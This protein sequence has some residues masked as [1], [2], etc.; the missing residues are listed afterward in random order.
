MDKPEG[1]DE[2]LADENPQAAVAAQGM[3][4]LG[5]AVYQS[6]PVQNVI[7]GAPQQ[8]F[9]EDLQGAMSGDPQAEN[10]MAQHSLGMATMGIAQPAQEASGLILKAQ[11]LFPEAKTFDE[12]YKAADEVLAPSNPIMQALQQAKNRP[13]DLKQAQGLAKGGVVDPS[14]PP[15]VKI[16]VAKSPVIES[17]PQVTGDSEEPNEPPPGYEQFKSGAETQPTVVNREPSQTSE[18]PPPGYEE[19]IRPERLQRTHGTGEQQ[20][21]AALEGFGRGLVGPLAPALETSLGVNPEDIRKREEANP[22]THG[23]SEL[24]GF[25]APALTGAGGLSKLTQVGALEAIGAKLGLKATEGANL[26]SRIGTGAARGAIDNILLT[27]GDEV[28]KMIIQD[29]HQ[30]AQ[31][32]MGDIGLAGVIGASLGGGL[33]AIPALWKVASGTKLG[34]TAADFKAAIADHINNPEPVAA[35]TSELSDLYK[36]VTSVSD[37]VYGPTGLKAQD[38]A[39]HLPELSPEMSEQAQSTYNKMNDTVSK[40]GKDQASYPPRLTQKL[41][42]DL[43]KFSQAVSS[44]GA[45]SPAVYNAMQD[46]KQTLQG[47]SKYD[48]FVKP[49]DE[50]YDFV[51]TSKDLARDLRLSLED[52]SVW[53][54]AA[55]RQQAINKAFSEYLPKLKDFEKKFTTEVAGDRVIDSG[56]INTYINQLG[57]PNAEIKQTL[58]KNFIDASDKYKQVI[59]DTHANLGLEDLPLSSPLNATKA[60]FKEKTLGSKLAQAVIE[61]GLTD[62]G[63]KGLGAATGAGVSSHL[64]LGKE[65]GAY[66]G[67]HALGPFFSSVLPALARPLVDGVASGEGFKAAADYAATVAKASN[68]IDK[69]TAYIFKGSSFNGKMY[70]PNPRDREKLD[71][72]LRLLQTQPEKLGN[73]GDKIAHYLPEHTQALS[74]TAQSAVNY[75]NNL[76][77][78]QTK[79]NPLDPKPVQ[80]PTQKALFNNALDVANQPLVVFDKIKQGTI[81]S[82]DI[83]ALSNMYPDLFDALKVKLTGGLATAISK[84]DTVPYKTR[85]GLS[86][87]LGQ[88]MDSTMTP[89]S[90]RIVQA[91]SAARGPAQSQQPQQSQGVKSSPALQKLPGMYQTPQQAREQHRNKP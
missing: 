16:P 31:T 32:A 57:K 71:K 87:F 12:L 17:L 91:M 37:E 73:T 76:R 45:G 3:K 90:I 13:V 18:G 68:R 79:R 72:Q 38:I 14:Y 83:A 22:I 15:I 27:G 81:N 20:A 35:V 23:A 84:G 60:T 62:V 48:K 24:A 70:E 53:G 50:A 36:N 88:P 11:K 47:Y 6:Q 29:P 89:D 2:F 19:F 82:Q 26:A 25:I 5:N 33:G 85:L 4:T 64:G 1:Y 49:V 46:L 8:Q 42:G 39:K 40:M 63:G 66:I 58:L 80:S 10:A 67:L 86:M 30:S 78:D 55:E 21:K 65:I 28:S 56:K 61:K 41:Q 9:K 43:D 34:Q 44:E 52:K 59:S 74:Q 77:S 69:A 75:L 51:R 7:S 54:K